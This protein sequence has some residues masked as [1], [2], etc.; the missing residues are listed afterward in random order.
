MAVLVFFQ[1]KTRHT[2]LF[3]CNYTYIRTAVFNAFLLVKTG[4]RKKMTG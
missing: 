1:L 2:F 4:G 3:I